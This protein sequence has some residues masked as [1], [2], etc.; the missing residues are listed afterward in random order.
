LHELSS[1]LLE[2]HGGL[3]L[4]SLFARGALRGSGFGPRFLVPRRRPLRARAR[5]LGE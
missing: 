4:G 3:R 1:R 5:G 2:Q